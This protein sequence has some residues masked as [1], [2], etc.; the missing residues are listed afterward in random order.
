MNLAAQRDRVRGP[1]WR[2]AIVSALVINRGFSFWDVVSVI[3]IN[4]PKTDRRKVIHTFC[5]ISA[6]NAYCAKSN[7][8]PV[9]L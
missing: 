7:V 1:H 5:A 3:R 4:F 9:F 6:K 2:R 8:Q